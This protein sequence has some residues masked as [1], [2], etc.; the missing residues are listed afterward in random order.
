[1]RMHFK[2]VGSQKLNEPE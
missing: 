1:M 2:Y